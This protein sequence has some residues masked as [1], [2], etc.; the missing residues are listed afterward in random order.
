MVIF[1]SFCI[2]LDNIQTARV[3]IIYLIYVKFFKGFSGP[4]RS[5]CFIIRLMKKNYPFLDVSKEWWGSKRV[6]NGN[7]P[8]NPCNFS[9]EYHEGKTYNECTDV[10]ADIKWCYTVDGAKPGDPWG[11]CAPCRGKCNCEW[12]NYDVW[13]CVRFEMCVNHLYM[14]ILTNICPLKY[15]VWE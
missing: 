1:I 14:K 3:H 4:S 5:K 13:F 12:C 2:F 6:G 15:D 9:F 7:K 8:G 11:E 10:D